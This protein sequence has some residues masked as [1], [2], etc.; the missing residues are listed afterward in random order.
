VRS[1]DG[2]PT[3]HFADAG[4]LEAALAGRSHVPGRLDKRRG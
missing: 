4:L 3:R 1:F 2:A